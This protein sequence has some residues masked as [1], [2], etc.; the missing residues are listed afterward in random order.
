[1]DIASPEFEI[2]KILVTEKLQFLQSMLDTGML[3]WVSSVVFCIS[4]LAG[5][6][7]K[8]DEL[9]KLGKGYL[10]WLWSIILVFFGTIV[11]YGIWI[12]YRIDIIESEVKTLLIQINFSVL[13]SEFNTVETGYLIGTSS[14]ILVFITWL[15]FIFYFLKKTGLWKLTKKRQ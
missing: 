10:L 9:A 14:F 11:F 5:V 15:L 13:L 12:I 8:Q 1:M 6:W 7:I 4:I 2:T 3:W